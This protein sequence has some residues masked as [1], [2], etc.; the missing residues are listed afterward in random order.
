MIATIQENIPLAELTTF[1]IGG[2]A[3]FFVEAHTEYEVRDALVFA[4]EHSLKIFILGGGSNIL[5]ADSGFDG[6]VIAMHILGIHLNGE[7][8]TV[9]AGVVWDDFV[10]WTIEHNLAGLECLSGIP[11]TVGGAVVANLGAYGAQCSDT[12]EY[13]EVFDTQDNNLKSDEGAI[14]VFKK[15]DCGFSYHDSMFG[16]VRGRVVVRATFK[17]YKQEGTNKIKKNGGTHEIK[18]PS[19]RDNRFDMRALTTILGHTPSPKEIRESVLMMR[20]EKGSLIMKDRVSYKCAGSFFH[21]PFVSLEKYEE[22]IK[23]A[24]ELDA[25]KEESLRPWAWKESD[26]L[27]KLASGFLL[28]YTE[29]KKNYVRGEVSISPRHTLSIINLSCARARAVADFAR[30]MQQAVENIF[31]ISLEREVEYVG[32]V[33]DAKR[34]K[35]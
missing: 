5:M 3:R 11:G 35:I 24:R 28:E 14:Q 30:D 22:V 31:G 20:E 25:V 15:E 21:M 4:Q 33:V 19:Y 18:N 2:M 10:V 27:Y 1:G 29:F 9:G 12:C 32:E 8:I 6:L 17:L 34:N 23:I 13:V 16:R 26:D 7:L